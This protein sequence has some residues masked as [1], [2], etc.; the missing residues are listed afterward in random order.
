VVIRRA[1]PSWAADRG[2]AGG[3][4]GG[5]E[6]TKEDGMNYKKGDQVRFLV[7]FSHA[8]VYVPVGEVGEV[9][10]DGPPPKGEGFRFVS[11]VAKGMLWLCKP[12][13]IELIINKQ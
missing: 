9:T 4:R 7:D 8:D 6:G 2:N 5:G 12:E 1:I 3:G 13:E 10:R 11:V